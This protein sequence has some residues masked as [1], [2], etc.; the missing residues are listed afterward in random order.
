MSL[1]TNPTIAVVAGESS[2]D[3]LASRMLSGLRPQLA[4]ANL[5]GIGGKH[6]AEYGFVSD[7]PMET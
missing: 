4:H 1:I 3:L 2:G 6:M 7:Y 5:H